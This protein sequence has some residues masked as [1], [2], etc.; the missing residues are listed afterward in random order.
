[1]PNGGQVGSEREQTTA[2]ILGE[3]PWTRLFAARKLGLGG[4]ERA[5]PLLPFALEAASDQAVGFIALF[6][7]AALVFGLYALAQKSIADKKTD[8]TTYNESV[9]LTALGRLE[10]AGSPIDAAT[11]AL[12]AWS[13]GE[14][15]GAKGLEAPLDLLEQVVPQ[16]RE[17]LRIPSGGTFAFFSP[18][19]TRILTA[20]GDA[21]ARI[22][23]AETGRTIATL[24]G[25]A[26]TITF[27]AFSPDGKS[28]V[29]A[30]QDGTARIWDAASGTPLTPAMKHD[31]GLT[32]A[33]FSP[34]GGRIV[35][36]GEDNTAR[37]WDAKSGERI[38][39]LQGHDDVV[40]S[41]VF[42][43]E[44]ARIVTASADRTARIWNAKDGSLIGEPL[45][46]DD[47][48]NSAVFSRDGKFVVTASADKTARIWDAAD[49]REIGPP[50]RHKGPVAYAEFSADGQTVAT[51]SDDKTAALW[52]AASGGRIAEMQHGGRVASA[53]FSEDGERVVTAS[54]DGAAR[55]FDARTGVEA[56]RFVG[57]KGKVFAAV[58]NSAGTRVLTVSDD[59]KTT[60]VWDATV[61]RPLAAFVKHG[62]IVT[63]VA[64]SP[65]GQRIVT[66]SL[67]K[68]ARIWDAAS[69]KPIA[70]LSGHDGPVWS[71]A[72]SPDGRR[73]VTASADGTA[74]VDATSRAVNCTRTSDSVPDDVAAL[75]EA[76]IADNTRRA[77][78]SDLAHFA[79]WGGQVPA[80]PALVASYLA[81][82]AETL[83]VATLV[84]RIATIS[85]AHEAR[86]L[87][88]PCRSEF[89]RATLRGIKRTRGVAQRAAKPLL[90]ED[91]FRV[92]DTHRRGH[93]GRAGSGVALDRLRGRVP[94][95]G[96]RRARLR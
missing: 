34:D 4:L 20:P 68:T 28:V 79:A 35:A 96:N 66:A 91:L 92:L 59:D 32:Y 65:D 10:A 89:V 62:D 48:V 93:E 49:G 82:H 78:R 45:K 77:Y 57:H 72:F 64:F 74:R 70:T 21:T 17:R 55:I 25:H 61:G 1:M 29:T 51:A 19:G 87:P 27:A 88:N 73:I 26:K 33:A 75:V 69:G 67:D 46:H 6:A 42:S 63:S 60:R 39:A 54:D 11:F 71:A 36:A 41:A 40:T 5:Q 52:D 38:V 22:W 85:K 13:G 23:D 16:L 56:A 14:D 9:A 58:F 2:L 30:S 15:F 18:D 81:A 94:A 43:P 50:F 24:K 7:V 47:G 53:V 76:S 12:A 84:R 86:G 83:S 44:G 3:R 37:V 80:E 95:I 31:D 90:R 8:E